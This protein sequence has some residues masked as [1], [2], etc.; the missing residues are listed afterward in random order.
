[1][2]FAGSQPLAGCLA[3]PQ[4]PS[5]PARYRDQVQCIEVTNV[6]H[7][8]SGGRVV[9]TF[10]EGGHMSAEK[11]ARFIKRFIDPMLKHKL[12]A[13]VLVALNGGPFPVRLAWGNG[14]F[15]FTGTVAHDRTAATNGQGSGA[16]ILIDEKAKDWQSMP[17]IV[18][19]PDV[20]LFHEL[21]HALHMQKG[22]VVN[23]EKEM[24]RRVIGIGSSSKCAVTENAY[25]DARGFQARC[26]WDRETL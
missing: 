9:T 13:N 7:G 23:D 18:D 22:T 17:T 26:C 4:L 11:R 19:H 8:R 16:T 20:G 1:M 12:A 25:R 2:Y 15:G 10:T 5:G 6:T 3:P 14:S 21:V 24:E